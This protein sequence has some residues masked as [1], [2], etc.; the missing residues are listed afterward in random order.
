MPENDWSSAVCKPTRYST[1][2]AIITDKLNTHI[3]MAGCSRLIFCLKETMII[4]AIVATKVAIM[5]G[6]KI[7]VGLAEFKEAL[8]AMMLTGISV[9]PEA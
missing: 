9:N 2:K 3:K 6:R 8:I 1:S 4:A 7:S 5:Q